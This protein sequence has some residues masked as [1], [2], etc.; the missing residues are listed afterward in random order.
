MK[1]NKIIE[2]FCLFILNNIYVLTLL[3]TIKALGFW[4]FIHLLDFS[5]SL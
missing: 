3:C 4:Y 5:Y 2:A 1:Y